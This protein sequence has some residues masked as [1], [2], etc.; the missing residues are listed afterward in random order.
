MNKR[1]VWLICFLFIGSL[2]TFAQGGQRR[3][4]EERVK[5]TMDTLKVNLKLEDAQVKPTETIF[6]D[7]YKEMDA[8]REGGTRPDRTVMEAKMNDRDEKL[9]KVLNADQ[10]TQ[11]KAWEKARMERMRAARGQ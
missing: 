9:K 8:L 6:T 3:T 1:I 2:T 4:V 5:M 7:Y 10:F 11:Y